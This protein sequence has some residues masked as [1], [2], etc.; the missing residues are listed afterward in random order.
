MHRHLSEGSARVALLLAATVA[1]VLVAF[2]SSAYAAPAG[3]EAESRQ[4]ADRKQTN[5]LAPKT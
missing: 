5:I 1:L 2:G 3:P 4:K